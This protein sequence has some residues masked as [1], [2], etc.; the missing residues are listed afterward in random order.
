MVKVPNVMEIEH[1][2]GLAGRGIF[3]FEAEVKSGDLGKGQ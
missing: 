2:L 1:R 3:F